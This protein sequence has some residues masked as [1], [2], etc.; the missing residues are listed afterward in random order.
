MFIQYASS[1]KHVSLLG[2]CGG[3]TEA[4]VDRYKEL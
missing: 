2:G 1:F 3:Q 4:A